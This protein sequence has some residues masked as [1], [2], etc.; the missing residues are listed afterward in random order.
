MLDVRQL[1]AGEVVWLISP[2]PRLTCVLGEPSEAEHVGVGEVSGGCEE[3][4]FS[5]DRVRWTGGGHDTDLVQ[6]IFTFT[7]GLLEE[8]VEV[9]REASSTAGVPT[10]AA[11]RPS[12]D[13]GC[14]VA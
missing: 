12:A 13:L 11:V 9:Y 1:A 8:L 14:R 6:E 2:P 10:A 5:E 4:G 3:G 7:K